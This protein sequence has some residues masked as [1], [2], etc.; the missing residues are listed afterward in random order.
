MLMWDLSFAVWTQLEK[1]V[2]SHSFLNTGI[3]SWGIAL[4]G[5][6]G[7]PALYCN[8]INCDAREDVRIVVCQEQVTSWF[9]IFRGSVRLNQNI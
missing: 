9:A 1:P 6:I 7:Q 2:N 8:L 5:S 3:L 4:V